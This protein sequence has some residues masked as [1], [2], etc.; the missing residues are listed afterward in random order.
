M[1]GVMRHYIGG[2]ESPAYTA[3]DL[4]TAVWDGNKTTVSASS[5]LASPSV[6]YRY[7]GSSFFEGFTGLGECDLV[8]PYTPPG[9]TLGNNGNT[10]VLNIESVKFSQDG[11]IM[12][13]SSSGTSFARYDLAAPYDLVPPSPSL[14][15]TMSLPSGGFD[16]SNDGLIL[17][18][19]VSNSVVRYDMSSAYDIATLAVTGDTFATGIANTGDVAL[20]ADGTRFYTVSYDTDEVTEWV[21][22]T[23]FSPSTATASG[24]T[25]NVGLGIVGTAPIGLDFS[26]D[27]TKLI[28]CA[29]NSVPDGGRC[30]AS[31]TGSAVP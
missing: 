20:S 13:I 15:G 12:F 22:A 30:V 19:M 1:S 23:P 11:M 18:A 5:T 31:F 9:G 24:A 8:T 6:C 21:M 2:D 3:M 26:P 17:F 29:A 27:Q 25:L 28:V 7:D 10:S 4:A 14:V 16:I